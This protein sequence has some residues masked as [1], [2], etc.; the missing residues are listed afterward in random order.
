MIYYL[1]NAGNTVTVTRHK[2]LQGKQPFSPLEQLFTVTPYHHL[3]EL[4]NILPGTYLF[5][6]IERLNKS[7]FRNAKR[8]WDLLTQNS[9]SVRSLNCP[10]RTLTR[11]DL[12]K[13]LWEEKYNRFNI[14]RVS[15]YAAVQNF[16]VFVRQANDHAGNTSPLIHTAEDLEL[17]INQKSSLG[18]L[19]EDT[20]IIEFLDTSENGIHYKYSAYV[21]GTQ[22]I[23]R[24]VLCQSHW[25]VKTTD[26]QDPVAIDQ[27]LA[28]EEAYLAKN[29][30]EKVLKEIAQLAGVQ[31]GR[32]DYGLTEDGAPQ[33]W[34]INTNP[35]LF[36]LE[37][38]I[39]PFRP[40]VQKEFFR[41][42]VDAMRALDFAPECAG[43]VLNP[44]ALQVR[45]RRRI[46]WML[47]MC[48]RPLG[49]S[50]KRKEIV[51]GLQ[52][53]LSQPSKDADRGE[54]A[55]LSKKADVNH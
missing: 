7:E 41:L 17:F 3:F 11:F 27:W 46:N 31:Y 30:H 42:F 39:V 21:V 49:L 19:D 32:I 8:I 37:T 28:M 40:R 16:P 13:K 5:S 52:H 1:T 43:P 20:V 54:F 25:M 29:P 15:D 47:D 9:E 22:I 10:G 4:K 35:M 53:R 38:S 23:P 36:S 24:H 34:E 55:T 44:Y 26:L 50:G 48:L 51:R 6:D 14:F 12:L 45:N 18:L 2:G 33:V